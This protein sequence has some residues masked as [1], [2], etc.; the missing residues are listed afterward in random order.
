MLQDA[1][2]LYGCNFPFNT[3]EHRLTTGKQRVWEV[4][5]LSG[6]GK[7]DP[8]VGQVCSLR[9][10]RYTPGYIQI[11]A[12]CSIYKRLSKSCPRAQQSSQQLWDVQAPVFKSLYRWC[13]ES[14]L[15]TIEAHMSNTLA[16]AFLCCKVCLA[17]LWRYARRPAGSNWWRW[18]KYCLVPRHSQLPVFRKVCP[19]LVWL[20]AHPSMPW[21]LQRGP[22]GIRC[23]I[24]RNACCCRGGQK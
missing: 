23:D 24:L 13:W 15:Y 10:S 2:I 9:G 1:L 20:I 21:V 12:Y 16:R 7:E 4:Q 18:G 19:W 14:L 11:P 17:K 22:S 3:S 6:K 8:T 5:R